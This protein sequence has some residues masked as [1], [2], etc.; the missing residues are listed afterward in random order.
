[1]CLLWSFKNPVH[2][3]RTK[4]LIAEMAPGMEVSISS[5]LVAVLGEYQ[6]AATTTINASLSCITSTYLGNLEESLKA[7]GIENL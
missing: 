2:E 4:T 5:E 7:D 1:M 3:Q 6:R